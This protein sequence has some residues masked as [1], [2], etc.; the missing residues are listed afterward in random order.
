MQV[1]VL[2]SW[3]AERGSHVLLSGCPARLGLHNSVQ[4][5][6]FWGRLGGVTVGALC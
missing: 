4:G 3:L 1:R 5:Y 6:L 2:C